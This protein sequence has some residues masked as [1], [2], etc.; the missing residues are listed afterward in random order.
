MG[1][2]HRCSFVLVARKSC[3]DCLTYG[4]EL[5]HHVGVPEADDSKSLRLEPG[6]PGRILCALFLVVA[7]VDLHDEAPFERYEVD[8]VPADYL[9]TAKFVP[10]QAATA[11]EKPEPGL[12][13]GHIAPQMACAI[14][15]P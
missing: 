11:E 2:Q 9:L 6:G 10:T 4:V 8:D 14:P 3:V 15:H 5:K 13:I 1:G 12:G 7:A